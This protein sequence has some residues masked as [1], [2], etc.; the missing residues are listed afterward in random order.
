MDFNRFTTKSAEAIQGS[1]QLAGKLNHPA[2]QPLHLFSVLLTQK[3]GLIP[4]L[5]KKLEQDLVELQEKTKKAL[6]ELPTSD[7]A[8]QAYVSP[9]LQKVFADAESEAGKLRD[10]YLSTEHLFLGLL[11]IRTNSNRLKT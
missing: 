11:N 6:T 4:S 9:E 10:E 7:Q 3:D 1:I 2:L 5:I 8:T